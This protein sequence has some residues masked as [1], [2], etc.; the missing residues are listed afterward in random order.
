MNLP[1]HAQVD[2]GDD[3]IVGHFTPDGQLIRP[4]SEKSF[5]SSQ[6]DGFMIIDRPLM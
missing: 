2:E 1:S 6:L 4:G 5:I 3:T